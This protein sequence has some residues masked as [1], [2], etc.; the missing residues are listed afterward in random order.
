MAIDDKKFWVIYNVIR[1]PGKPEIWQKIGV[2][3]TND[4]GSLNLR[5]DSFPVFG[6]CVLKRRDQIKQRY[7]NQNQ[8]Y[9]DYDNCNSDDGDFFTGE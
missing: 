6:K 1:R 8:D 5:Y 7:Q 2:G 3:F 4:D 9:D